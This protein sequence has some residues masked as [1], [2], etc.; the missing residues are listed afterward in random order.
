[1][2]N[3]ED[4]QTI[5][6]IKDSEF[7]NIEVLKV[8]LQMSKT[9][10]A[11]Q[12]D[13]TIRPED[14]PLRSESIDEL[15]DWIVKEFKQRNVTLEHCEPEYRDTLGKRLVEE[16]I[17]ADLKPIPK[18]AP[19]IFITEPQ[20]LETKTVKFEDKSIEISFLDGK[21]HSLVLETED[22]SDK[23]FIKKEKH[24]VTFTPW[25]DDFLMAMELLKGEKK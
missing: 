9:G 10:W 16:L 6:I 1:M 4:I 14:L 19:S 22:H 3:N 5:A 11:Y 7:G 18:D 20:K 23:R 25:Y 17:L 21:P 24:F 2:K 8:R 12:L 15:V 13:N